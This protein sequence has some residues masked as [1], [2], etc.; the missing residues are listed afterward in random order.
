MQQPRQGGFARFA[1]D[2]GKKGRIQSLILNAERSFFALQK[3][4]LLRESV[5][6]IVALATTMHQFDKC[7]CRI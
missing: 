1:L 7:C 2:S 3:N 5:I 6:G 4:L